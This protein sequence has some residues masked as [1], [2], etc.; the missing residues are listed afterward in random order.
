MITPEL[1]EAL[2]AIQQTPRGAD[3]VRAAEQA[4]LLADEIG[5][6]DGILQAR[7]ALVSSRNGVPEDPATSP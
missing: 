4:V 5:E 3:R 6:A 7:I 2:A 1:N